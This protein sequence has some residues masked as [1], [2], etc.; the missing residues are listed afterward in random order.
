MKPGMLPPALNDL[1]APV[2]TTARTESSFDRCIQISCIASCMASRNALRISGLFIVRMRHGTVGLDQQMGRRCV[3]HVS[4][5]ARSNGD[6]SGEINAFALLLTLL[7][8]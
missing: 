3:W 8:S 5:R 7:S 4:P 1:P 2:S 6:S